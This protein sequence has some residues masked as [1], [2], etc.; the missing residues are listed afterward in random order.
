MY[1]DR[2]CFCSRPGKSLQVLVCHV[3]GGVGRPLA[4]RH[5]AQT[6]TEKTAVPDRGDYRVHEAGRGT[7]RRGVRRLAR[8]LP[9]FGAEG[10][11]LSLP[12]SRRRPARDQAGPGRAAHACQGAR[13][14]TEEAA[15]AGPGHRPAARKAKAERRGG[16]RGSRSARRPTRSRIWSTNTSRKRSRARSAVPR[17]RGFSARTCCRSSDTVR[18]CRSRG[19]SCRTR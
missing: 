10:V 3:G 13:R 4:R 9:R 14:R 19:A 7:R 8:V 15:G 5:A 17:A 1:L 16:A 6:Y 18:R 12:R 2:W 11:L